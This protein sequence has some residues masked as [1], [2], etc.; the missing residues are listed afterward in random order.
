MVGESF[1]RHQIVLAQNFFQPRHLVGL[2]FMGDFDRTRKIP[3]TV[4]LH[5]DFHSVAEGI[6]KCLIKSY[7]AHAGR[8]TQIG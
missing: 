8:S 6:A 2:E 3:Q 5:G 1:I 7:A 4:K